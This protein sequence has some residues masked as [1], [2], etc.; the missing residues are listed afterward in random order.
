MASMI[1]T[2][3][4]ASDAPYR[5]SNGDIVAYIMEG[6]THKNEFCA[7]LADAEMYNFINDEWIKIQDMNFEQGGNIV[8]LYNVKILTIGGKWKHENKC[9]KNTL[10]KEESGSLLI[11]NFEY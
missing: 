2:R 4:D 6:G 9:N 8:V 5:F 7:L 1:T 3:S 10:G 11:E